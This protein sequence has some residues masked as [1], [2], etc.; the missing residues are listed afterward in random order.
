MMIP[1]SQKFRKFFP[2]FLLGL[3][4]AQVAISQSGWVKNKDDYFI[5]ADYTTYQSPNYYT[6]NNALQKTISFKQQTYSVYF[7][8]G[9]SDK[10]AVNGYIPFLKQNRYSD[11]RQVQG[12]GDIKLEFKHAI[13]QGSIPVAI[14]FTPEFP[15]GNS[16]II[17][18]VND[19]PS[20]TRNLATGDGDFNIWTTI[21]ASHSFYPKP[22]YVS[23]FGAY[24]WRGK[25]D[26]QVQFGVEGGCKLFNKIWLISK[27]NVLTG[28]GTRPE[29][30]D[31]IR[32]DWASN[33]Q[34]IASGTYEL[35]KHWGIGFQYTSYN[36][37]ILKLRNYYKSDEFSAYITFNKKR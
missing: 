7:E 2:L 11:T 37:A 15:V 13:Q 4:T 25:F 24:N 19:N 28:F 1:K 20:E 36:G 35:G 30:V 9:L 22:F 12:I 34:F 31:F 16:N 8:Y 3:L 21:A 26:D 29:T 14:S 27:I 6:I 17:V 18:P 23:A 10:W 5:K 32:S 33:T